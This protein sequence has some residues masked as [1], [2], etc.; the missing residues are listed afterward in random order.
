MSTRRG[1]YG[2]WRGLMWLCAA[3]ALAGGCSEMIPGKPAPPPALEQWR[4]TRVGILLQLAETHL[5]SGS[6]DQADRFLNEAEAARPDM[7][8]IRR[9]A[10]RVC[11]ERGNPEEALMRLGLT[12]PESQSEG[13]EWPGAEQTG[14]TPVG[15][16]R[17]DAPEDCYLAG[18][19][20]QCLDRLD[21]AIS[22]HQ[23]AWQADPGNES[24]FVA[25]V[26]SMIQANR[27]DEALATLDEN[28]DRFAG[29]PGYYALRSSV[30]A[31]QDR[32]AEAAAQLELSLEL[33]P[34]DAE[35]RRDLGTLRYLT[36]DYES[37]IEVL[38]PIAEN[39]AD[40]PDRRPEVL[41]VLGR[42]YIETGETNRAIETLTTLTQ[43]R[44]E[45]TDA[46]LGLAVAWL[47]DGEYRQAGVAADR[48]MKLSPRSVEA[49]L[50]VAASCFWQGDAVRA[51]N[52]LRPLTK[53]HDVGPVVQSLWDEI[54]KNA[55]ASRVGRQ[56]AVPEREPIGP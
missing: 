14:E 7:P 22:M 45:Q 34:D 49:R 36:G 17:V 32:H 53:T 30:L 3:S 55:H 20:Y 41:S 8:E 6:L 15:R 2:G 9:L 48:A 4:Q 13:P 31:G 10:A 47:A 35:I 33:S 11:L 51:A 43:L 46:W 26:E 50:L 18:L 28:A 19:C 25:L 54:R 38:A 29:S 24:R 52:V 21:L 5:A 42:C 27:A 1:P 39:W 44:P 16:E 37:A 56:D 23:L 40:R 12:L